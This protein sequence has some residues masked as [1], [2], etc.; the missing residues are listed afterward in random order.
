MFGRGLV[1]ALLGTAACGFYAPQVDLFADPDGVDLGVVDPILATDTPPTAVVTIANVGVVDAQ[2]ERIALSGEPAEWITVIPELPLPTVLRPGELLRV[3]LVLDG[4]PLQD[5]S[6]FG[7]WEVPL[8]VEGSGWAEVSRGC[9]VPER[10]E[11][12][13]VVPVYLTLINECDLDLDGVAAVVC[14]GTDCADDDPL[15]HPGAEEICNGIDDDCNGLVDDVPDGDGDSWTICDGDCDDADAT[16]HPEAEEL[17][18]GKDTDCDGEVP[19]DEVD[20]DSDTWLVCAGD[21]DD[22]RPEVYPGA[23]ELC[24]GLDNDCNEVVDDG[25]Y[26]DLDADG[27][28]VCEGDCDDSNAESWPGAP[29]LCDGLDNDCDGALPLEEQDG[30]SDGFLACAD[31]CDDGDETVYPGAPEL[32][33]DKDNDCNE[34]VDDVP[35]G[36][37]DGVTVCEGDCDDTNADFYPGAPELCDGL[38]ND[39]DGVVPPDEVDGDSDGHLACA[40]CNDESADFYPGAPELC[41][42][43]DNDCDGV[44]PE[45][46]TND[47]DDDGAVTC[48]DCDDDEETVYPGAPE[49]CDGLDNDCDGVIPADETTDLDSDGFVLCADC[50]DLN[51][52]VNPDAEELCNGIDD[53]CDGITLDGELI[54]DDGDTWLACIDCVDDDPAIYPGAVERCNGEDDDCDGEIDEGTDD[55]NDGDGFSA[56]DGDCN[57]ANDTIYPGAP[58]ECD[59]QDQD[60]DGLVDEGFRVNGKYVTE[61]HCG[62]CGN[63]CAAAVFPNALGFC[64]TAPNLPFCDY[65][66]LDGFFD[67]NGQTIDGCECEYLGPID[68]PF[69]GI[70]ANCDGRDG[71]PE[72]AI[73]V[74]EVFGRPGGTGTINDPLDT[75]G[76]GVSLADQLGITFVVVAA[77]TYAEDVVL[78]DGVTVYGGWDFAFVERDPVLL[79]TTI[80]GTGNGPAVTAAGIQTPT[81]FDGFTVLGT[82]DRRTGGEAIAMWIEDATSALTVSHNRL[83]AGP[84]RDGAD[85]NALHDVQDGVAGAPGQGGVT[86]GWANCSTLPSGGGFGGQN[87]CPTAEGAVVNVSGGD[88]GDASCPIAYSYQDDGTPG[89]PSIGQGAGFG[90]AGG[91]DAYIGS[92]LD[93]DECHIDLCWDD[94]GN[95]GRGLDGPEGVGGDGAPSRV[96]AFRVLAS[97]G[98]MAPAVA[99]AVRA[100]VPRCTTAEPAATS[101]GPARAVVPAAVEGAAASADKAAEHPSGWCCSTTPPP[102]APSRSYKPMT[103]AP[104]TAAV[105][106][107]GVTRA[108]AAVAAWEASVA[109]TIAARVGAR[110]RGATVATVATVETAVEPVVEPEDRAWPSSPGA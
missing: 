33:D 83:H 9:G 94:G 15:V 20:L 35:D 11:D 29:E 1:L 46:E 72:D 40:D 100:R 101:A 28:D 59:Y 47:G 53:D 44:V 96:G 67:V 79:Q 78:A 109:T 69:D 43:L 102:R 58:E 25:V 30:D 13:E 65:V 63:D 87:T 37:G 26:D 16:V 3:E 56:C 17:C 7:S 49:L 110:S 57:D 18:D 77:G 24:D 42:G 27:W 8:E 76:G 97:G 93:C 104:T 91:C 105:V 21:C 64:N 39:C 23:P 38:D 48:L 80:V 90:G 106:A 6:V 99:V 70:D 81:V 60:C 19:T 75:I 66:C 95:G 55:D 88:G 31:D 89:F 10:Q 84:G 22:S 85:G 98:C 2:V 32:C 12:L 14:G 82:D 52:L 108:W 4:V 41:D 61:A 68:D 5:A 86:G 71:E 74:S 34:L 54:D 103:S 62:A 45:D 92:D 107:T 36:D 73:F 51:P 50:D